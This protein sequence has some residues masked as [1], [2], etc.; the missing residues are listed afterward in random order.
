MRPFLFLV[1]SCRG[2]YDC[3]DEMSETSVSCLELFANTFR[4]HRYM[5]SDGGPSFVSDAMNAH[6]KTNGIEHMIT[7]AHN[8]S[9]HGIVERA[10]SELQRHIRTVTTAL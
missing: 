9:A 8:P 7:V 5:R 1:N 4:D 6:C 3:S 2:N 10:N